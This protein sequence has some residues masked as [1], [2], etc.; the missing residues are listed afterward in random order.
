MQRIFEK[1]GYRRL[2]SEVRLIRTMECPA[3]G[4]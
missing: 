2:W 3:A 4:D 1:L